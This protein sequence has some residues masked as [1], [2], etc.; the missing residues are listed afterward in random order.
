M[1]TDE[2]VYDQF[3]EADWLGAGTYGEA[4]KVLWDKH[5][6]TLKFTSSEAEKFCVQSIQQI[7]ADQFEYDP[8]FPFPY[9]FQL[10]TIDGLEYDHQ[11]YENEGLWSP[12]YDPKYFYIREYAEPVGYLVDAAV[13]AAQAREI[14]NKY[15]LILMDV[16][17]ENWGIIKRGAEEVVVPMD[18]ACGTRDHWFSE[19]WQSDVIPFREPEWMGWSIYD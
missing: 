3:G 9:I 17:R 4:W 7:Q 19:D 16:A 12:I 10:R 5:P 1:L 14:E 13:L 6:A 15:G 8:L 18:L 11:W 2:W